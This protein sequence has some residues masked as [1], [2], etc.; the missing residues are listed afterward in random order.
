MQMNLIEA[1]LAQRGS[2]PLPSAA[3]VIDMRG[4]DE[5]DVMDRL[6]IE[7]A[8]LAG[9][10]KVHDL[11]H[12]RF[13]TEFL[14]FRSIL[15]MRAEDIENIDSQKKLT[16]HQ[17]TAT[18]SP[19]A[20]APDKEQKGLFGP[21]D[22][23]N[24]GDSPSPFEVEQGGM[25]NEDKPFD[26]FQQRIEEMIYEI[27]RLRNNR[28][29][30][31]GDLDK[32]GIAGRSIRDATVRVIFLTEAGSSESLI[33]AAAYAAHLKEHFRK[34]D[35]D[36]HQT[37]LSTTV[38]CLNYR[39]EAG[40]ATDLIRGLH[41]NNS[42]DHLDS[43]ILSEQ[44]RE[45]AALIAGMM[46]TY[47]AE[48]LLYV[49][50]II[51]PLRVS[52]PNATTEINLL[53]KMEATGENNQPQLEGQWVN[54]PP[55][56]YLIGMAA[57]E[58]SARW[59]RRWI[60]YRMVTQAIEILQNR[61]SED[62]FESRSIRNIADIW[63]SDWLGQVEQAI[64]DKIPGN[65][66]AL[67][68]IPNAVSV[69]RPTEEAFTSNSLSLT[70]SKTTLT[71]LREYLSN[72]LRTY[73]LPL[74]E[75]ER[76]R[77]EFHGGTVSPTLQDAINSVPQI[78]QR[79]REWEDR[80]PALKKG[81]PLV[82]AQLEAQKVLSHPSFFT[83][84]NGAVPRAR[85]QLKELGNAISEF[86]NDHQQSTLDVAEKR[87]EM[88]KNGKAKID[89][90]ARHTEQLPLLAAVFHLKGIMMWLTFALIFCLTTL[91]TLVGLAWLRHLVL[92]RLPH[93]LPVLDTALLV[94][95]SP[96]AFVFWLVVLAIIVAGVIIF[97]RQLLDG[98]HS[99]LRV[100]FI[101]WMTL[102]VSALF[103]LILSFSIGQLVDDPGSL[104]LLSWL[105]PLPSWSIAFL[106]IA[107]LILALEA[108][109]FVWWCNHLLR[110]RTNI[111]NALRRQHRED[112]QDVTRYIAETIALQLL[113]RTGLT[114]GKGGPGN[115]Y[116]RVDQLYKRLNEISHEADYQQ[117]LAANRLVLSLS[118]TQ[119]GTAASSDEAW[120]N[121]KIREEWLDVKSLADG[122]KRLK[123]RLGKEAEELKEF[124]ELLLRIMG[125]ETPIEVE[126]QFRE[127]P[128]PGSREQHQ[129]QVLIETL[130]AM[131]MRFS[132]APHSVTSMTPIIDRYENIDNKYIHQLPALSTLIDT[133]GKKVS[134]ATLQPLLVESQASSSLSIS[135]SSTLTRANTYLATD[136][137][138]TWVQT[139][140]DHK[141]AKLE[142]ILT[143]S[144]V[145]AK[146][147][148]DDAYDARAVMR[149]LQTRTSLFGRSIP[150]GQRGELYLLLAPS[151]ESR[152]FRQSLNIPSR[153]IIDFPDVERLLLLYVQH[154]VSESLFIPALPAPA[155]PDKATSDGIPAD[156]V[157]AQGAQK[158]VETDVVTSTRRRKRPTAPPS[159]VHQGPNQHGPI[160]DADPSK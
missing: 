101:F 137:F 59:G 30:A 76:V 67:K 57:I 4:A 87:R 154:Y 65:I 102:I 85:V 16:N 96:V 132:V 120:L 117:K 79:L 75:R 89:D 99:A 15:P 77:K 61:A 150:A 88:E 25:I 131:A 107:I 140:W 123:E 139:L 3:L 93:F 52:A 58:H 48:L 20:K 36:G 6:R 109:W 142:K 35:R 105:S 1:N 63:L 2:L 100:E 45:D 106:I 144:G 133:L 111:I 151:V 153:L 122:Y 42:W 136:A 86:T 141:D 47:L 14:S 138:A 143:Q 34:L 56:T 110:E 98:T 37:M 11:H 121:L 26:V 72:L 78:E 135:S 114:D 13:L 130:A 40:P 17:Q 156:G 118:E 8:D 55:T 152:L 160:I 158:G 157:A 46:Q 66:P 134:E 73:T 108:G 23:A 92:L 69:A 60:N 44:Y 12:W 125:E 70:I 83:G 21:I 62:D 64:P 124:S 146:L 10:M 71:D 74:N 80:D 112:I 119:P 53:P 81:T 149:R 82:N 103:G 95:V 18:K 113:K 126:Q 94:N 19:R 7:V 51:P 104:A 91:A 33:S 9:E 27:N 28:I 50:L 115:Y 127:K 41:W 97:G 147:M 129:A 68:A 29:A 38:I 128:F 148:E 155:E 54:L 22:A 159:P 5:D 32:S 116:N 145:L 49:L 31:V 90:L 39:G 84:A 24:H 43:L